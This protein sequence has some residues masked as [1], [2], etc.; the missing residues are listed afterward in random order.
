M[1]GRYRTLLLALGGVVALV[2]VAGLAVPLFLNADSFRER[3]EQ[4]ISSSLGRKATLGKLDLSVFSGSLVAENASLSDDP[5]FSSEPFLTAKKVKIG[6]ELLPLLLS[7]K[8]SI[9]GFAI[10]EPKINLIRHA[11]G[12]WNYST[13]G[14]A[15]AA[16][17]AGSSSATP[18]VSIAKITVTN[19]QLTVNTEA[20]A[21]AAATPKRTY[22]QLNI[23]AKNFTFE[24]QFPYNVSA[25]LPGDGTVSIAGN[26]GPINQKDASLTPFSAKLSVKHLDPTAAGFADAASGLSGTID[27]IDGTA[28]WNGQQLHVVDL[29]VDTP[30]LTLTDNGKPKAAAPAKAPDSSDMMSTFSADHLQV[31]NGQLTLTAPGRKNPAVYQQLNAEITGLTPTS[32][33]PFKLTAQIPGGGSVTADGT[34]GPLN[35]T[36]AMA[37]PLNAHAVLNHVDLAASGV[38]APDAGIKGL[39]NLDVKALSDGKN[40]NA[41]VST[42]IQGLQLAANG[43]PSAKP[44][45]V[46]IAVAQDMQTQAGQVQ[47]A[48]ITIGRAVVNIGG[49]YQLSGSTTTLNLQVNGQALPVDELQEFLP[50]VG[51]HLPTGSRLQGGTLTMNLNVAGSSAEPV[52]SGPIRLENT[53]LAGFDLG[54]K[55]QAVTA[56]TGAKTGSTTAIRSLSTNIRV[57]GGN[58]RT[59]NLVLDMP[60][61][62]TATGAG[63]VAASGAL[64]YNVVLKL[65]GLLGSGKGG[66]AAGAGGIAGALMGMIPGG[67]A[68]GSVGGIAA[69][70]LRNGIPVAIGGTTSNPTFTPNMAGALSSGASAFTGG[71]KNPVSKQ[72]PTNSL[73]N[74]LGGLLNKHK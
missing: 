67:G 55:L 34:A 44:V 1:T 42:N 13:I 35:Q 69:G 57:Q 19:G 74:A 50:S 20:A 17:P 48:V 18:D 70:A 22:D 43:S 21:G 60:A 51:V 10:D 39:A 68:A 32:S 16:K 52:I 47:K 56:L 45:D 73:T 25:H 5:A 61:L 66:A 54:S 37:T 59:D 31:K 33:A 3:I 23:E 2:V 12:M 4:E 49:T 6:V 27:A 15:H 62:G 29:V 9:T 11:D 30:K 38:V 53:N 14:G 58:V 7:K 41:N 24:K 26:V 64:N 72:S 28:T 65:T 40:L 71:S 36:N 8:V 46:Q 63:T